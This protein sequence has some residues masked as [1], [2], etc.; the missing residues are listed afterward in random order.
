MMSSNRANFNLGYECSQQKSVVQWGFYLILMINVRKIYIDFLFYL[1][2][3]QSYNLNKKTALHSGFP[4]R[5]LHPRLKFALL[6]DIIS[7]ICT[8]TI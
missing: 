1:L 6:D 5:T 8:F 3:P 4:L 7:I 2:L